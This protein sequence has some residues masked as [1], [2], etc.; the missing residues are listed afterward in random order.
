MRAGAARGSALLNGQSDFSVK[1]WGVRGSIPTP[2]PSTVKYGGNTSCIEMRCGGRI[3]IFDAGSGL[4]ELG[5]ALA[6]GEPLDADL[7]LSH[8][9]Y[10]HL[11]GLPFFCSAFEPRNKLRIWAGH[12]KPERTIEEVLRAFMADPLFP[13]PLDIFGA[14]V[15]F[16]DFVAG[17]T[18][19]PCP[20]VTL[21]TVALNHPNRATGYRVE[22]A[23]K[24]AC[25][26]TDTEHVPG[27][28]DGAVLKLIADTDL[29]IYDATYTDEE[30]PRFQ[31]WGH[32]TWE[33]AVR[34]AKAARVKTLALFHH[35]PSHDDAVLDEIG[36]KAAR[37]FPGA[38]IAR[39]GATLR[40]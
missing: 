33:E 9:H 39:E 16:H 29:L 5:I 32:S 22:F 24:S 17:E 20:G 34:L 27:K 2:G 19:S 8:T 6:K 13:V 26:V 23:G 12:L 37:E 7:F 4:R 14:Q 3:L 38:I 10:D 15:T 36:A 35:E 11:V 18:L 21:R 28:H 31:G 25:Y 1:F 30:Y 40:P